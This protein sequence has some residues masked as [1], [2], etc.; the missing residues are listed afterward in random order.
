M[1]EK[2]QNENPQSR[3]EF[4]KNATKKALPIIGAI[5]LSNSPLLA[6]VPEA[7]SLGC[8]SNCKIA[9]ATGCYIFCEGS[10]KDSCKGTCKD[11]CLGG[12]NR[13]CKDLST[14]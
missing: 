14:K 6:K 1:E 7:E 11:T 5:V 10:C 3:R 4:F 9:C 8:N 13:S 2:K 12:C